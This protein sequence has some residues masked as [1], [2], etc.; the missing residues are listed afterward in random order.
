MSEPLFSVGDV[1]QLKSG[2]PDMTVTGICQEPCGWSVDCQWYDKYYPSHFPTGCLAE[3]SLVLRLPF[4]G[5]TGPSEAS[6][7][8]SPP[9]NRVKELHAGHRVYEKPQPPEGMDFRDV[10]GIITTPLK[11]Y[12]TEE[13]RVEVKQILLEELAR[14]G[15]SFGSGGGP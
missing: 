15:I 8:E 13:Q 4:V 5:E 2:G 7:G 12:L 1:V 11:C 9:H 10:P 3:S 6:G 14:H